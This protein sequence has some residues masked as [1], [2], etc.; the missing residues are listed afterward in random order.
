VRQHTYRLKGNVAPIGCQL[1][2]DRKVDLNGLRALAHTCVIVQ[3]EA[4]A[5]YEIGIEFSPPP[6]APF[7]QFS[8]DEKA[9]I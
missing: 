1:A 7:A 3:R 4:T 5:C 8:A 2:R 6:L 9:L